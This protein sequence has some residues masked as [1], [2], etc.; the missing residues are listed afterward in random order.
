MSA[1]DDTVVAAPP[2]T[3]DAA[4][5]EAAFVTLGDSALVV[6]DDLAYGQ[7]TEASDILVDHVQA[8]RAAAQRHDRLRVRLHGCCASRALRSAL[9]T[10]AEIEARRRA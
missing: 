8:L 2:A 10:F 6:L 1:D 4:P 7:I 9:Q 5:D 3:G